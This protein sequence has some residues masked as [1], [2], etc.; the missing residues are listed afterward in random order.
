MCQDFVVVISC[1]FICK[2]V[3][4]L[5]VSEKCEKFDMD[6]FIQLTFFFIVQV[7]KR[8]RGILNKL[9]P[10]KFEKLVGTVNQM[11]IDTTERLSAVIDLIFEKVCYGRNLTV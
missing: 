4:Y 9:T 5:K 10:E 3:K 11:P 2:M 8:M 1:D 7:V 6:E